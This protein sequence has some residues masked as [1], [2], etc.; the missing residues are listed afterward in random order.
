VVYPPEARAK[1][2]VE[3]VEVVSDGWIQGELEKNK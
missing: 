2:Q 3:I 1:D